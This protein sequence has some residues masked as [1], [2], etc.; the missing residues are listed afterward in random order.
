MVATDLDQS[1]EADSYK[2]IHSVHLCRDCSGINRLLYLFSRL[3]LSE[4]VVSMNSAVIRDVSY[5]TT[6]FYQSIRDT[7]RESSKLGTVRHPVSTTLFY[8]TIML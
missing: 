1:V 2:A 7:R 6:S 4:S 8:F 5:E 3:G